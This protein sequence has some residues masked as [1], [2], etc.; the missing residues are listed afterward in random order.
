MTWKNLEKPGVGPF[1]ESGDPALVDE[2]EVLHVN[3]KVVHVRTPCGEEKAVNIR[4]LAP[5]GKLLPCQDSGETAY[6]SMLPNNNSETLV[7][8]NSSQSHVETNTSSEIC[9]KDPAPTMA[10]PEPLP[11]RS[12]RQNK[13]KAP[14]RLT[15]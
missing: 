12:L 4:D 5:S 15:Y 6:D 9:Q 3:P 2:V 7:D 8:V 10:P 1:W 13:G 14:E 11:R